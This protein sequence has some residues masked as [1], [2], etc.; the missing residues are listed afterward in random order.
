MQ[1]FMINYRLTFYQKQKRL[2]GKR[3]NTSAGL[4]K[5]S[6]FVSKMTLKQHNIYRRNDAVKQLVT[7]HKRDTAGVLSGWDRIRFCGTIRMLSYTNG[8]MG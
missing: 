5:A 2:D 7:K 8:L 6:L 3:G 1:F 4:K